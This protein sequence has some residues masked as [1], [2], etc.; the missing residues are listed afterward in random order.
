MSQNPNPTKTNQ[1]DTK[2]ENFR[3]YLEKE[4]VLETLTKS[5]V[6]I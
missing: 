6:K 2:R 3:K 1:V 5:L 4:G